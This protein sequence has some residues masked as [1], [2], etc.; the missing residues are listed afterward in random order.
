VRPPSPPPR[1]GPVRGSLSGR[2]SGI[3]AKRQGST[4]GEWLRSQVAHARSYAV[5]GKDRS[6]ILMAGPKADGVFW[7]DSKVGFTTSTAYAKA[8]PPWLEQRNARFQERVATGSFHWEALS[9]Q[10]EDGGNYLVR[11][12]RLQFGLPRF[13]QG[14]GMP[15]DAAFWNRFIMSPFFDQAIL[16]TAEDE[17]VIDEERTDLVQSALKF[18]D[19][20]IGQVLTPRIDMVA[21]DVSDSL[22]D[23]LRVIIESPSPRHP[24]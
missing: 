18:D 22:D 19:L 2:G 10:P 7:F 16:E 4:L 3:S 23:I 9:R 15:V 11:G 24:V 20:T 6:A 8:L 14:V 5:T 17:G 12:K 21:I 13:I 1:R